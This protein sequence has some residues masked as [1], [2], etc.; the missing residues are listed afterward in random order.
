MRCQRGR[1]TPLKPCCRHVEAD[2]GGGLGG[3]CSPRR[4]CHSRTTARQRGRWPAVRYDVRGRLRRHDRHASGRR[5]LHDGHALRQV[6]RL[7]LH[8]GRSGRQR[9][10]RSAGWAGRDVPRPSAGWTQL[11][12]GDRKRLGPHPHPESPWRNTALGPA[13]RRSLR[14]TRELPNGREQRTSLTV[15]G[16]LGTPP[17]IHARHPARCRARSC[18]R[19]RLPSPVRSPSTPAGRAVRAGLRRLGTD[20]SET[21]AD[22][23]PYAAPCRLR[24]LG[25]Y[26]MRTHPVRSAA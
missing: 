20:D 17:V 19:A 9:A 1:R 14:H 21:P 3:R 4:R 24:R 13:L 25:V 11:V 18:P 6:P 22:A 16:G 10:Q 23:I 12:S 5:A 7:L 2:G 8:T 26:K 15:A